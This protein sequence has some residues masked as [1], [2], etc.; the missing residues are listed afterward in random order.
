MDRHDV[1]RWRQRR[2]GEA[3]QHRRVVPLDP[4]RV[5]PASFALGGPKGSIDRARVQQLRRVDH[6]RRE[7]RR[8]EASDPLRRGLDRRSGL[9][10][11]IPLLRPADRV[12][13]P[14]PLEVEDRDRR[15]G[16]VDS[17][18]LD[19][20][21]D[22]LLPAARAAPARLRGRAQKEGAGRAVR[23]GDG[24]V[25]TA[26]PA[27][28]G[29]GRSR[30]RR[31]PPNRPRRWSRGRRGWHDR[32]PL[33]AAIR[34]GRRDRGGRGCGLD[35][36]R[37]SGIGDPTL[38]GRRSRLVHGLGDS[39]RVG[40]WVGQRDPFGR[41]R[42]ELPVFPQP[43]V[44]ARHDADRGSGQLVQIAGA[45]DDHDRRGSRVIGHRLRQ[46]VVSRIRCRRRCRGDIR[47]VEGQ[48]EQS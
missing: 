44:V 34:L 46:L 21:D 14:P 37:W 20:F 45:V 36:G 35:D 28:A 13:R 39:C 40:C 41:V 29:R 12:D 17:P 18:T 5:L 48:A 31:Q 38:L 22:D 3:I 19:M 9:E 11:P 6:S 1:V 8:S 47:R 24:R 43:V 10:P 2:P 25:R 27:A 15:L 30:R 32:F 33:I 26:G 23:R 7:R 4:G 42:F 16:E